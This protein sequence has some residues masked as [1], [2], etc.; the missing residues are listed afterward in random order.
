MVVHL[1]IC[2]LL[3]VIEVETEYHKNLMENP[4]I[5]NAEVSCLGM[6]VKTLNFAYLVE[7]TT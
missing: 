1:V 3:F 5:I 4:E 7:K 2:T 6:S